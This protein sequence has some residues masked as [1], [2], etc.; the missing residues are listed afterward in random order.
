MRRKR[1]TKAE[2]EREWARIERQNWDIF[3]E[4]LEGLQSF[5]GAAQLVAQAVQPGGPGR[6]FYSN[7]GFFLQ[8]F[9]PPDGASAV[10]LGLYIQL[11]E[12]MDAGGELKPGAREQVVADLRAAIARRGPV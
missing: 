8:A 9:I 1:K 3:R 11:I 4:R 12:R 5:A 10:E 2:K 7:L 6:R